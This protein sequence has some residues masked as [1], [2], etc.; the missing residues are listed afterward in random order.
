[1]LIGVMAD[2]H[3]RLPAVDAAMRL[4]SARGVEVVIHAG[5]FVAPFAVR[6]L[7]SFSGPSHAVDGNNDG[8]RAG[9]KKLLPQVADGPL[10][11]GFSGKRV[12]VHHFIDWCSSEDIA[13]ADVVI[14]GHTHEV[15]NRSEKGKLYLNP[16][17]CC[18]WVGGRCT[19]ALLDPAAL[20]AE[21]I[22]LDAS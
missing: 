10:W 6:R 7:L 17:E 21:I 13:R 2:T 5:D 9:L 4:F 22:E 14:T 20:S 11:V 19:V 3:D 15:V 8:E 1:M 16:G 18:G 12:L